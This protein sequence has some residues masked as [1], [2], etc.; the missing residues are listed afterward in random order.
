MWKK[1]NAIVNEVSTMYLE[2]QPAIRGVVLALLSRQHIALLGPPGV[3]KSALVCEIR[4]RITGTEIF[5]TLFDSF[6]PPEIVFGPVSIQGLQHDKFERRIEGYAPTAHIF[7]AEEVFKCNSALLNAMLMLLNERKYKNGTR[8]IDCPLISMIGCSNEVPDDASLAAVYDRLMLRYICQYVSGSNV[9]NLLR[10]NL[11]TLGIRTTL[12]LAD[13]I[14]AQAEVSTIKVSEQILEEVAHLKMK[15][16]QEGFKA[17]DRRW[18]ASIKLLQACAYLDG[19]DSVDSDSLLVYGD[20]LWDDMKDATKCASAVGK[21]INPTLT[22]VFEH[23]DA[24]DKL[25]AELIHADTEDKRITIM[26]KVRTHKEALGKLAS[27]SGA[28]GEA[29]VA[30]IDEKVAAAFKK[31]MLK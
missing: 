19:R 31:M 13:L 4:D 20:V 22:Q 11:A 6:S 17:S 18:R 23:V 1:L 27:K 30:R 7:V 2:R 10:P 28:K 12:S 25:L 21:I 24:T 29:A 26:I 14:Q 5:E 16:E 15:M 3:S 9:V 8:L